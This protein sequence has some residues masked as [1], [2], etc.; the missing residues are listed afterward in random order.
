MHNDS[1]EEL[2]QIFGLEANSSNSSPNQRLGDASDDDSGSNTSPEDSVIL[3]NEIIPNAAL[4]PASSNAQ[5]RLTGYPLNHD[6]IDS[7]DDV[8]SMSD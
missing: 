1:N 7:N 5:T 8:V 3:N 4:N 2:P 6:E